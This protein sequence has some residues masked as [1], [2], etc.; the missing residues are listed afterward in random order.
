MLPALNNAGAANRRRGEGDVMREDEDDYYKLGYVG[1]VFRAWLEEMDKRNGV[2]RRQTGNQTLGYVTKDVCTPFP[3]Y[4]Y[5]HF[6]SNDLTLSCN[7]LVR[8]LETTSFTR[9]YHSTPSRTSSP[10]HHPTSQT[11]LP[12]I[13]SFLTSSRFNSS[14]Y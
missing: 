8:A 6:S 11:T 12:L 2:E 4:L 13:S 1:R 5:L 7:S 14:P 10:Q 9:R 3:P